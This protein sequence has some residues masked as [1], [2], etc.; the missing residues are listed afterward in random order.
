M[1]VYVM[2]GGKI[3]VISVQSKLWTVYDIAATVSLP[4]LEYRNQ[5]SLWSRK[6]SLFLNLVKIWN[7]YKKGTSENDFDFIF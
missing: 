4:Q 3:N 7:T 5:W 2:S 6:Q 1:I